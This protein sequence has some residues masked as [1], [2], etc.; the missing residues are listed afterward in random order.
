MLADGNR[1]QRARFPVPGADSAS[2]SLRRGAPSFSLPLQGCPFASELAY[3][4][5]VAHSR[6]PVLS[7]GPLCCALFG[8]DCKLIS[9]ALTRSALT[10]ITSPPVS[11]FASVP[12]NLEDSPAHR[13]K[14]SPFWGLAVWHKDHP[15][16]PIQILDTHPEEFSFISHSCVAHQDHDVLEKE[17]SSWA[18]VASQ[19]S[20][21]QFPF[22][23]IV[24]TKVS[25]MLFHHFDFRS[26]GEHLPLLRFV[27]HSSQC[28]QSAVGICRRA[29][30]RQLLG[31]IACNLVEP[32]HRNGCRL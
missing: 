15:V 6:E 1:A 29:R 10:E 14:S 4:S 30:K 16:L 5:H 21:Y 25:S 8:R 32:Q 13:N 27:Q 18:P 24:K 26:V 9:G 12:Q 19:S 23:V 11:L 2:R 31:A 3:H 28:S 7:E 20:R 22:R 17:T